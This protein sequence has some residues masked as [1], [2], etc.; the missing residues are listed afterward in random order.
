M[1]TVVTSL[2]ALSLAIPLCAGALALQI[3]NPADSAEAQSKHLVL[4]ARTTAC[5]SPDKTRISASAEGMA[6]GARQSIPLRVIA[7]SVPGTFG[8]AQE[9]PAQGQWVVKVVA[10]NPEYQNYATGALVAFENG[11]R[12]SASSRTYFHAPTEAETLALLT[13]TQRASLK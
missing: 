1:R 13:S 9:W 12:Q 10:T 11:S 6:N 2:A 8:V 4:L 3:L 5:H 7:L